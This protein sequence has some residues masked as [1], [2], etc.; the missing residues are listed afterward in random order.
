MVGAKLFG[1]YLD[2]P[3]QS[4]EAKAKTGFWFLFALTN[5]SWVWALIMVSQLPSL[6]RCACVQSC[7]PLCSCVRVCSGLFVWSG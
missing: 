3:Q 6:R 4:V 1:A 2:N 5:T 7:H